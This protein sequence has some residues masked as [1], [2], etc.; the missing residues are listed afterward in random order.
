MVDGYSSDYYVDFLDGYPPLFH[1][2][3]GCLGFQMLVAWCLFLA[4][5]LTLVQPRS[6]F[7]VWGCVACS[8]Y[9]LGQLFESMLYPFLL[10]LSH[11]SMMIQA[12]IVF[13]TQY[14]F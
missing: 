14:I 4:W 11:V 7:S 1:V 6:F 5:L 3:K 13:F 8:C 12:S 10:S 9:C 2:T